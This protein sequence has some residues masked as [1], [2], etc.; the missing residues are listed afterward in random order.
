[1]SNPNPNNTEDLTKAPET[2][3]RR[4]HTPRIIA[5][6]GLDG[7]GKESTAK[8]VLRKAEADGIRAQMISFPRYGTP[9]GDACDAFQRGK[10]G[11][12]SS[13]DP[14]LAA[15]FYSVDRLDWFSHDDFYQNLRG[16]E[17]LILDRSYYSNFIHQAM[18]C[19]SMK[20][21]VDWMQ[22]NFVIECKEA[23]TKWHGAFFEVYYLQLSEEDRQAQ[24][25]NRTNQDDNE[26]NLD[27]Q[28]KC[29]EFIQWSQSRFFVNSLYDELRFTGREPWFYGI[30]NAYIRRVR[31]IPVTHAQRAEDVAAAVDATADRIYHLATRDPH[32]L[33]QEYD[34][35]PG[36]PKLP[37]FYPKW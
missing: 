6:E 13:V 25:A 14:F 2:F 9:T 26:T 34:Y 35:I 32:I 11:D 24:M 27:Y 33:V 20:T 10:F 12:P 3:K 23:M 29:N 19:T 36:V 5:I 28:R 8:A 21:L 37:K 31:S 18:K 17:L 22:R 7:T 15:S 16:N 4:L 1:M 30:W